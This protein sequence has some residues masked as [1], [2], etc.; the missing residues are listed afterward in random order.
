[1]DIGLRVQTNSPFP[2][3]AL[4]TAFGGRQ[5]PGGGCPA[6]DSNTGPHETTEMPSSALP[7]FSSA[8]SR[9]FSDKPSDKP[10]FSNHLQYKTTPMSCHGDPLSKCERPI[11]PLS[12]TTIHTNRPLP[13]GGV[14]HS[15]NT[16]NR[17]EFAENRSGAL[18]FLPAATL[19]VIPERDTCTGVRWRRAQR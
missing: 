4:A 11:D 19:R 18:A 5:G 14:L 13:R 7:S 10:H 9:H 2:A 17:V 15:R 8:T 12:I 1:M 16:Q 6:H 3:P